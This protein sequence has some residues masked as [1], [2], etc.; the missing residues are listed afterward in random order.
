[1]PPFLCRICGLLCVRALV[2]KAHL[3]AAA[4]HRRVV[5]RTAETTACQPRAAEVITGSRRV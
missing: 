5:S 1:M 2:C 3:P 4:R